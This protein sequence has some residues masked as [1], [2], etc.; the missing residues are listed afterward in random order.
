M[1]AFFI[2]RNS[3]EGKPTLSPD[4]GTVQGNFQPRWV[5]RTCQIRT[6]PVDDTW[7]VGMHPTDFEDPPPPM[8]L[9]EFTQV[10]YPRSLYTS[11]ENVHA[12][13]ISVP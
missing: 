5:K 1:G 10:V 13:Q 9:H 3:L 2:E 8:N 11:F 7:C 6:E 4:R 12:Q